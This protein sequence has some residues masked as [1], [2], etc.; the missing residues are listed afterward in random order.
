MTLM[1]CTVYLGSGAVHFNWSIFRRCIS[2]AGEY[3]ITLD[4][5][6]TFD[7]GI[8]GDARFIITGMQ[9]TAPN[10][11]IISGGYRHNWRA[12]D[13]SGEVLIAITVRR[14]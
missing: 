9:W 5:A 12:E 14:I 2:I 13:S 10:D 3:P 1:A 8:D 4:T 11:I 6:A 7:I